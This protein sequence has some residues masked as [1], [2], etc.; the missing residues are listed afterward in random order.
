MSTLSRFVIAFLPRSKCLLILWLQSP[1]MVI[2]ISGSF[3]SSK[4]SLYIWKFSV[5]VLLKPNLK[6]FEHN[7]ASMW[8]KPNCIVVWTFFCTALL[9]DWDENGFFQ[10]S[11]TCVFQICWHIESSILTASSFRILNSSARILSHPLVLFIVMLPKPLDLILQD[12]WI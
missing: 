5:H 12:V 6:D 1:I 7:L 8:N 3:T 9:W 11:V 2:L 10:S 4:P